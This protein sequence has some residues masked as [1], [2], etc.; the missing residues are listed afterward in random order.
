MC[1]T[2][3]RHRLLLVV[4]VILSAGPVCDAKTDPAEDPCISEIAWRSSLPVWVGHSFS[5][6]A[7]FRPPISPSKR[8]LA[9][10]S[11]ARPLFPTDFILRKCRASLREGRR[12]R[13]STFA[14]RIL[15]AQSE[16]L[17]P[18]SACLQI[19]CHRR[20]PRGQLVVA[21]RCL[22]R[23]ATGGPEFGIFHFPIT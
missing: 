20:E 12:R 17:V 1:R 14:L 15:V 10:N 11:V 3:I 21:P 13:I 22:K 2:P 5:C 16:H 23:L 8:Q 7:K 4:G 9:R 19:L 18:D 6:A